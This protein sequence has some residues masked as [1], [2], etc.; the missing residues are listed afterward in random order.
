MWPHDEGQVIGFA[1][2]PAAA[3]APQSREKLFLFLLDS[4][5][6][7]TRAVLFDHRDGRTTAQLFTP[8]RNWHLGG[9]ALPPDLPTALNLAAEAL[10]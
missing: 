7:F 6:C 10:E 4:G 8:E 1:F 2:A 9:M 5:N 3:L